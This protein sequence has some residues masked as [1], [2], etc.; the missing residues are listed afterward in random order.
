MDAKY[1]YDDAT[2][3][4]WAEKQQTFYSSLLKSNEACIIILSRTRISLHIILWGVK[5]KNSHFRSRISVRMI[6]RKMT[7]WAHSTRRRKCINSLVCVL[8]W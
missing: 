6:I 5:Y 3:E 4:L 7:A 2:E 8:K 1:T